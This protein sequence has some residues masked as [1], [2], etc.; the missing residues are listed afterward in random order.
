MTGVAA[1]RSEGIQ[2]PTGARPRA[3]WFKATSRKRRTVALAIFGVLLVAGCGDDDEAAGQDE[4]TS[5][6]SESRSTTSTTQPPG[7]EPTAVEPIVEDLIARL[8]EVTDEIVREPSVVLN[9][10]APVLAELR[11]V[12]TADEY[13]ARVRVYRENAESGLVYEPLNADRIASTTVASELSTVDDNTV[14]AFLCVLNTYRAT[15]TEGYGEVKDGL[16]HPGLVTAVRIDGAWRIERID[17]DDT[18]TCDPG[19]SV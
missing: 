17:E 8:D 12:V 11:E 9:P 19:A 1:T 5:T 13:E 2:T 14:Q 3:P 7:T 15:D 10:D 6:T 16:A 18:Q 4:P